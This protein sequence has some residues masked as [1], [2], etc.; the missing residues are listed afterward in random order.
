MDGVADRG[1]VGAAGEQ[2]GGAEDGDHCGVE[3]ECLTQLAVERAGAIDLLLLTPEGDVEGEAQLRLGVGS[4]LVGRV[5][6]WI[7]HRD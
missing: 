3:A 1:Q 6:E 4:E 5:A 2:D 7:G